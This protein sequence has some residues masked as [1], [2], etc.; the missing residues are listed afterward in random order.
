VGLEPTPPCGDRILS[1]GADAR[2]AKRAK[3]LGMEGVS[4]GHH[5]AIDTCKN[6]AD[7][8]AVVAAWPDLPEVIR[9][10]ILAMVK[11]AKR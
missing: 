6:D 2:K 9:G 10:G 5:L 4:V 8:A 11:T 1:P 7:L 3:D